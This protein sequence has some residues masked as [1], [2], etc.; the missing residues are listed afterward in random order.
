MHILVTG[1]CGFIGSNLVR[2]LLDAHPDDTIT[3]LDVLTYAACPESLADVATHP[4][5]RFLEGDITDREVVA[6]ALRGVDAVMHLAAESHVDRSITDPEA[7]VR[8]NVLGTQTLL[9]TARRQ[10]I[11][12]FL[13]CST[14]EVMGSLGPSGL[15][16]EDT[17]IQP[18]SPY[19]ASKAGGELLARAFHHTYGMETVVTRCSNNYGPF[20]FPEKLIP[21]FILNLLQGGT[22]PVYGDGLNVR[23]WLFVL[24]HC[25][26]MDTVLRTGRPGEVYCVG[27]NAERTNM[28]ITRW[29]L[30]RLK[31]DESAIRYVQDRPGHDR[32]Y[33]IDA[34][35]IRRELGWEPSV[36][37]EEGM[38]ATVSWYL[39][40][41]SWWR[42]LLERGL[43]TNRAE[44]NG[45][46][47]GT[48]AVPG[49]GR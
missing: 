29:L 8:T 43:D 12:R 19:S 41:E 42:P 24:D 14:D 11:P 5:Y 18:N 6:E 23:D 4:R 37:F 1:G 30:A 48:A 7:F 38:E 33:A 17:P 39:G 28:E 49:S 21:L 44:A 26:A 13:Y 31:K 27:G 45:R 40:H 35:K 47:T 46:V 10:G 22:V 15:F 20:Q 16:S 9:D 32:R 2:H 36:G 25:R 3:N 34:S